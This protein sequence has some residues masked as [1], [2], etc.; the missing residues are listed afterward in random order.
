M[1]AAGILRLFFVVQAICAVFFVSDIIVN[2]AGL[3][4]RPVTWQFRELLEIF[5]A[6]GLVLGTVLGS[7]VIRRADQR[8][9]KVEAQLR[10]ASGAFAEVLEERFVEWGL[11]PAEA[12][13]ALFAIKGLSTQDIA[14]MRA[15]SEGTI[16][17]QCNAIYKKA[18]VNG[19]YQLLSLFVEDLLAEALVTDAGSDRG[20]A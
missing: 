13:V 17:A 8:R 9:L 1:S 3:R 5:A 2:I 14:Q 19:R 7:V 12:D 15:T 4:S 10:A 6:T 16:K 20:S 18:G 11:T